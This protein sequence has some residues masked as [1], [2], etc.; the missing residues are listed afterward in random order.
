LGDHVPITAYNTEYAD[1]HITMN[2][3]T[4]AHPD[5]NLPF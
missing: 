2:Q 1:P 5:N 4:S 3:I